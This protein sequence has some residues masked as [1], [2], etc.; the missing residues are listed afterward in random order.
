M[1]IPSFFLWKLAQSVQYHL[2][3]KPPLEGPHIPLFP[4]RM[5]EIVIRNH[6]RYLSHNLR[7]V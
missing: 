4:D 6:A 5:H 3:S 2:I 7:Y 1:K